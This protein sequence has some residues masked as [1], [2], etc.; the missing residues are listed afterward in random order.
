MVMVQLCGGYGGKG[1]RL[2]AEDGSL[3]LDCVEV[4]KIQVKEDGRD[5]IVSRGAHDR[6]KQVKKGKGSFLVFLWKRK[7][8]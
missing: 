3:W 6:C 5:M 4:G 7:I 8:S 2:V 1:S